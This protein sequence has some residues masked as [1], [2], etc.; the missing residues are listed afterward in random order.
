ML[1]FVK[2]R[3][4]QWAAQPFGTNNNASLRLRLSAHGRDHLLR[5]CAAYSRRTRGGTTSPRAWAPV[6][7]L[8]IDRAQP[9]GSFGSMSAFGSASTGPLARSFPG[10]KLAETSSSVA[11]KTLITARQVDGTTGWRRPLR[12]SAVPWHSR[13]ITQTKP[14]PTHK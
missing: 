12:G 2:S 9:T 4:A 6:V 7:L 8:V 14:E 11:T 10:L 3:T 5:R 1:H 13:A